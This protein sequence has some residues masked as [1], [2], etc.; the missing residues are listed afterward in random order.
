MFDKKHILVVDDEDGL[1][2]TLQKE[3]TAEGYTVDTASDGD[4]AIASIPTK[5][6]DLVLLDIK[7]TRVH[8]MEVLKFIKKDYPAVKVIMLTA[9]ADLKNAMESR[10]LGADDFVTKPYDLY[11]LVA[12][13]KKVLK[14]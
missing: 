13:I 11:D 3:L 14:A 12:T 5:A 1:R 8:G 7:M 4:E 9:Y 6:F 10:R 2:I